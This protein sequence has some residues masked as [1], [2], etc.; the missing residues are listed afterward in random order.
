M[1]RNIQS[2]EKQGPT[3]EFILHSKAISYNWR[4]CKELPRQEAA[5]GVH[6]HQISITW[7]V[8]RSPLR[9]RKNMNKMTINTCL[10][11]IESK[12]KQTKKNQTGPTATDSAT[13]NI[14][15]AAEWEGSWGDWGKDEGIK[16]TLVVTNSHGDI[17]YNRKYNQ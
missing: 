10:S 7:N 12:N 11:T 3:T 15:T 4:T 16:Y 14:L 17:K 1:A 13:E 6:H 2:S 8:K 5:K 9:I